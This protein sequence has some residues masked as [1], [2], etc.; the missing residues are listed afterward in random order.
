M[1]QRFVARGHT[2]RDGAIDVGGGLD[3]FDDGASLAQGELAIDLRHFDE[4]Q[5]AERGLRMVR[6]A[7][8]DLTVRQRP[9]P[10]VAFGVLQ[11]LGNLFAH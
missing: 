9:H 3:R 8:L 6:D 11:I 7:D 5:I 4:H 10:L 1:R 2:S